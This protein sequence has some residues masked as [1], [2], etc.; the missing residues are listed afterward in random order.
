M[1]DPNRQNPKDIEYEYTVAPT[2]AIR[3]MIED[4][5]SNTWLGTKT[6]C[7]LFVQFAVWTFKKGISYLCSSSKFVFNIIASPITFCYNL[8]LAVSYASAQRRFSSNDN[9]ETSCK[10]TS[11]SYVF[12]AA[13]SFCYLCLLLV[14]SAQYIDINSHD[15]FKGCTANSL[16][17][18][19]WFCPDRESHWYTEDQIKNSCDHKG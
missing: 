7:S 3:I 1:N 8:L 12:R 18:K 5:L 14:C 16:D 19:T 6:S 13:T 10:R 2:E 9:M 11:D 15:C 4:G 17:S